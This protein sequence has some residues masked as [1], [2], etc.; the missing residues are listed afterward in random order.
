MAAK[1]RIFVSRNSQVTIKK[2]REKK[3]KKKKKHYPKGFFLQ[4]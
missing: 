3:K 1:K 4:T 2:K